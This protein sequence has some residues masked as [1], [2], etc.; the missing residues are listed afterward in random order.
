MDAGNPKEQAIALIDRLGQDATWAEI[1]YQ[2]AF[3][4]AVERGFKDVREVRT[5]SSAEARRLFGLKVE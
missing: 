2:I 4:N 5:V 1:H 3:R